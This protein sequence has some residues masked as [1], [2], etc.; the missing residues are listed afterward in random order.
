MRF[1]T[2]AFVLAGACASRQE[3][4]ERERAPIEVWIPDAMREKDKE[5]IAKALAGHPPPRHDRIP[6]GR[7]LRS[8]YI[9]SDE[10]TSWEFLIDLAM[11]HARELDA[12][13][14]VFTQGG[15][16][17]EIVRYDPDARIE[18]RNR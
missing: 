7:C 9:Y 1:W 12:D 11:K 18:E 8:V 5:A 3:P 16:T 6:P 17:I 4:A 15:P 13:A 14:I 2:T 10:D